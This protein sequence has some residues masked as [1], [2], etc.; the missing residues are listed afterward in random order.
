MGKAFASAMESLQSWTRPGAQGR[1][2]ALS[3]QQH[4]HT[5]K[6]TTTV[7][8]MPLRAAQKGLQDKCKGG[9]VMERG[10]TTTVKV[11]EL[12]RGKAGVFTA[13]SSL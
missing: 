7:S 5:C 4:H 6:V 8:R 11:Q 13:N 12:G 9:L 2:S 3:P 1:E 10:E